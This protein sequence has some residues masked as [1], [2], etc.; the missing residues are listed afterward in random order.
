MAQVKALACELPS[1]LGLPLSRFSRAELR[2]QVLAAG[3]VAEISGVTIWRWLHQD[4]IRPWSRRSWV[5][6]RDPE[7]REK[8]APVLDLYQ[9]TWNGAD[10]GPGEFVL[11]ADEKTQ[12]QIRSRRHPLTPPRPGRPIRVEHEYR[13]H[14]TCAYLAA[15]DV[16][17]AR[18]FGQL[19]GR[20]TIET[21]DAFV[22]TVMR[23]E[24]YRSADR[25]FWV[26]DN[27]TVHRG[28]RS[29]VRLREHWPQLRLIH[30]PVHASW[31]NQ[32]EI[33]FSV[34]QRQ[35]LT[36]DDF[37]SRDALEARV[38]GFQAHY[39]QVATPFE[40]KFTRQDLDR[41]LDRCSSDP[42]FKAAA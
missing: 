8:A 35:A 19:A 15:W 37:P 12:L 20:A 29:R 32:I 13:R 9:R 27:G 34:L 16:H 39:Q 1:R 4:A 42:N 10:L 36:P 18:L 30:L 14:G 7:F 17:R 3:L 2:R 6:P 23:T 33:Y 22:A 38:L 11:S 26:V 24:P 41:L 40:W 25:V 31:L 28:E 21:F 5:F